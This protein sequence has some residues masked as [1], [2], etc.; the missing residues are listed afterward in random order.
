MTN[1]L[2]GPR[3]W[4][5]WPDH[6]LSRMLKPVPPSDYQ[7]PRL[8]SGLPAR[9]NRLMKMDDYLSRALYWWFSGFQHTWRTGPQTLVSSKSSNSGTVRLPKVF[10]RKLGARQRRGWQ[11]TGKSVGK[12]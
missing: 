3:N 12:Y 5:P 1:R 9:N 6:R 4:L 10:E 7:L 8:L 11:K 2:S